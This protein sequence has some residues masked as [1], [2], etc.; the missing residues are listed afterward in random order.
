MTKV[1]SRVNRSGHD[2]KWQKLTVE[3]MWIKGE[4]WIACKLKFLCQ[5]NNLLFFSTVTIEQT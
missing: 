5:E 2:G 1:N 3:L 4:N